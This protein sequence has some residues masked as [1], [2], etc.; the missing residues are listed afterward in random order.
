[1]SNISL[2]D[3]D[4]RKAARRH[5]RSPDWR[6]V[7]MYR[8]L[9]REEQDEARENV[10]RYLKVVLEIADLL[11][12]NPEARARYEELTGKKW[13]HTEEDET[14]GDHPVDLEPE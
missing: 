9:S 8:G 6:S 1:M 14:G 4:R 2:R 7:P 10:K 13:S 5:L 3:A 11:D 12:R